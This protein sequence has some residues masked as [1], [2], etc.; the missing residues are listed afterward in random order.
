MKL[1]LRNIVSKLTFF[2]MTRFKGGLQ[3]GCEME[4][5]TTQL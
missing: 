3:I 1:G 5:L 4:A 2:L